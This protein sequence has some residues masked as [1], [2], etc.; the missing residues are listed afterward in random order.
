MSI[1]INHTSSQIKTER[2]LGVP[3]LRHVRTTKERQQGHE[4]ASFLKFLKGIHVLYEIQSNGE[5]IWDHVLP[6]WVNMNTFN[7]S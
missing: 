5:I 2:D 4:K 7:C 3:G 1:I 6:G